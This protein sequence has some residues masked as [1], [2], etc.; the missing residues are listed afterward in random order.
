[1]TTK[2]HYKDQLNYFNAVASTISDSIDLK[3]NTLEV[4]YFLDTV[5]PSKGPLKI[6]DVGAG[7][8]RYTLSLLKRGHKVTAVDI[9]SDLLKVLVKQAK[10]HGCGKDLTT[11]VVNMEMGVT[12]LENKFDL[13]FCV[14]LL[15]HVK[16]MTSVFKNMAKAVRPGGKIAILEPN[17]LNIV[18]PLFLVG[19]GKWDT[20]KGLVR[21]TKSNLVRLFKENEIKNI[22]SDNYL[23]V[24]MR[25]VASMP[26][27]E[28]VNKFL[29]K[30]PLIKEFSFFTLI[31]G[32]K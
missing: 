2:E 28:K 13:V 5:N 26:F 30:T 8:G 1:M 27:L 22:K 20:E 17:P 23:F 25:F 32:Q 7:F 24:P 3:P 10:E 16:D 14:N 11:R 6:L 31:W 18:L 29:S 21:C 4:D 15:H 19:T 12:D 9:S